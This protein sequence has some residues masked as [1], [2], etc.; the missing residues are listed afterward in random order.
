MANILII[1]DDEMVAEVLC[2]ELSKIHGMTV[3]TTKENH[4]AV[5]VAKS[6]QFDIYLIRY[7]YVSRSPQFID[8]IQDLH[9]LAKFYVMEGPFY[10]KIA[11]EDENP[12]EVSI[13]FTLNRLI[14][15]LS[16][17]KLFD[18]NDIDSLI[19]SAQ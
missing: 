17:I 2:Q 14:K 8:K 1:E 18:Q 7:S 4:E 19:K 11:S 12:D 16:R 3:M 15:D 9:R 5:E 10:R 13:S 6:I